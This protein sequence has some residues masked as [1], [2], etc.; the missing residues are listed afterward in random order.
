MRLCRVCVRGAQPCD[1]FGNLIRNCESASA[2]HLA[3]RVD[4]PAK[5]SIS[6][7]IVSSTANLVKLVVLR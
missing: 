7:P 3:A 4:G 2:I 6:I 5:V 1:A